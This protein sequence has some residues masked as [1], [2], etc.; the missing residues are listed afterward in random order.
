MTFRTIDID[1]N[2]LG[3]TSAVPS[4][5]ARHTRSRRHMAVM[6]RSRVGA[7]VAGFGF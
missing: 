6:S 1:K 7:R 2:T 4:I 3:A 5:P